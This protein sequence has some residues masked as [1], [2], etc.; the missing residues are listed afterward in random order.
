MKPSAP[1]I[2]SGRNMGSFILIIFEVLGVA[3]K[4]GPVIYTKA[5][6]ADPVLNEYMT[7]I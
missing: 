2:A 5:W 4:A 6:I 7:A 3:V 1:K